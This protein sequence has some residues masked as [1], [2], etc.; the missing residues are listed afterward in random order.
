[1]PPQHRR[2]DQTDG[3]TNEFRAIR[4]KHPRAKE[5]LD[6]V[7]FILKRD[8]SEG[9]KWGSLWSLSSVRGAADL[10]LLT[11]FYTFDDDRVTL[12]S[13]IESALM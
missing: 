1:M 13:I 4:A 6:G 2:I 5:F 8:P 9:Y 7:L 12:C 3:F 11:V 10:P